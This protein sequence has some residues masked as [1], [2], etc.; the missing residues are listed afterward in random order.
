[1]VHVVTL[2]FYWVVGRIG[3]AFGEVDDVVMV[4]PVIVAAVVVVG[5]E[6]VVSVPYRVSMISAE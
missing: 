4:V 2:V 5:V 3:V 6:G 1:M